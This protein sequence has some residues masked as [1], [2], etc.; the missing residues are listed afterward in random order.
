MP[1]NVLEKIIKKKSEKL[2]N[3][4]K[5]ISQDSLD[6]LIDTNKTFIN[7]KEKIENNLKESKFSIIAEIKKASPSAGII[8]KDYDPVQIAST[9]NKNRAT[10]LSVLTEEDFFL[11]NLLHISKIKQKINL[12][13]LCKDFFVDKFQV[14]LAK[15]YGADAV[16]IIL[17]GV[18]ESLAN[19]LY[20]EALRF[21]MSVIVEVHT[22]EEAK[23]ALKFKEA[24]IGINN[25]NLK[26]LKTD[27]NTTFD[28]HDVLVDHPG[29]LISESGIKTKEELLDLSNKTSIKTFLIGESLLKDLDNNSIFSVL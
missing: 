22:V 14:P 27:I 23:Q 11:G 20:E 7:F 16:L 1:E 5:N 4:K 12:P 21:N 8:I 29:P 15:S 9:Y 19:D 28:I 2:E 24:L 10:C 18:S 25:R 17:A 26:T 3:L 13:I 6:K